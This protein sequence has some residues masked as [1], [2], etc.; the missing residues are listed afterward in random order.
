MIYVCIYVH[1]R[2][3]TNTDGWKYGWKY[4]WMVFTTMSRQ[5]LP[6][7]SFGSLSGDVCGASAVVSVGLGAGIGIVLHGDDD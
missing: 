5:R 3:A 4:G 7:R 6:G 1:I 2:R